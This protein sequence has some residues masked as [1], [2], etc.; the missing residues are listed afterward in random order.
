MTMLA[1]ITGASLIT[2]RDL[3]RL[4]LEVLRLL[5]LVHLTMRVIMAVITFLPVAGRAAA[6]A[7]WIA[8]LLTAPP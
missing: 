8:L 5:P 3:V 2:L 6:L 7:V 1:G 4:A